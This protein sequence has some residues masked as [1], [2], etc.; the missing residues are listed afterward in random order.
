MSGQDKAQGLD[1]GAD[2][3]LI[4]PVEPVELVA[5]VNALLRTKRVEAELRASQAQLRD[6]L[7]AAQQARADAEQAGRMKDEFLANLSHELRTPLNAILGWAAI[8]AAGPDDADDLRDG[9]DAIQRNARAQTRIIEDLLDMSRI[10]GGKVRLDVRPTDLPAAVREATDTV[11]PAADAKGVTVDV[12]LDPAIGP[13]AADPDRLQQVLWNLLSNAIKF[14]PR[15]G[16]VG[17]AVRHLRSHLEVSVT[18]TG[19]GIPAAFL[20]YVFDRF[21][22]VDGSTTRRHGGLGLGLA[23]AKQLVELHG[24]SIR[25]DSPGVGQ[26]A[27]FTVTLPVHAVPPLTPKAAAAQAPPAPVAPGTTAADLTGV[28][29]LVVDDEPDA[30]EMVRRLLAGCGAGVAT[31]DSADAAVAAMEAGPVDV[32]VS[33]IGLPGED[34]YSLIRRVRGLLPAANAVVPAVAL[35]AYARPEDRARTIAAGYQAHLAKPVEPAE[36]IAVVA[37][38]AAR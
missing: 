23:I 31:A 26:G 30:R 37:A 9:L 5:T 35:T 13:I 34:G 29:V 21:R 2:A 11:R 22:Q 15:H 8:L 28:R 12:S 36:L 7:D 18:D 4:R 14:T 17:V 20:P 16:R 19:Q 6:A 3:Y 33:D 10:I 25:A 32:L 1:G 27:T 38:L 24:G